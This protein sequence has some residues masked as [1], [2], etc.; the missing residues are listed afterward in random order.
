M[1]WFFNGETYET[2]DLPPVPIEA[3]Q[4]LWSMIVSTNDLSPQPTEE[5]LDLLLRAGRRA[6]TVNLDHIAR[7]IALPI[8]ATLVRTWPGEHY[9][10]LPAVVEAYG[11]Q[12]VLEIGAAQ[13]HSA[14]AIADGLDDDGTVTTYDIT[15]MQ[16]FEYPKVDYRIGDLCDPDFR[17]TQADVLERAD[18]IFIDSVLE[19]LK[20]LPLFENRKRLVIL[21][22]VRMMSVIKHWRALPYPKID[23]TSFGHWSGTGLF[24]VGS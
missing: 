3:T 5:L 2:L 16:E 23:A 8:Q 14:A 18:V 20:L 10:F 19:A 24:F 17:A 22:D 7:Q 1:T 11:A 13:G 9:R 21:D 6:W 15:P 4:A 12:H